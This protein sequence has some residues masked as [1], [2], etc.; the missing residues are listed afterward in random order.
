MP[1]HI[2]VNNMTLYK[3]HDVASTFMHI[4]ETS[5]ARWVYINSQVTSQN[6]FYAFT[7]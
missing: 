3:R 1:W 2:D 5:S 4:V 7:K 6:E